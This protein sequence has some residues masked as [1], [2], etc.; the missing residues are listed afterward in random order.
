MADSIL[1]KARARRDAALQEAHIWEE[2]IRRYKE[3]KETP[4]H[5]AAPLFAARMKFPRFGSTLMIPSYT[6]PLYCIYL[7]RISLQYCT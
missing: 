5:I 4:L 6:H 1:K 3:L 2:F 7:H